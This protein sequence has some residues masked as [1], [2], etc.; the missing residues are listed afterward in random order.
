M[1]HLDFKHKGQEKESLLRKKVHLRLWIHTSQGRVTTVSA[2]PVK[3]QFVINIKLHLK[4][5]LNTF[6]YFP[7]SKYLFIFF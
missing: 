1:F 2:L 4:G 6:S 7:L 5:S 3:I